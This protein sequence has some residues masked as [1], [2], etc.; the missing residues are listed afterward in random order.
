MNRK[1]K[2]YCYIKHKHF[3]KNQ[4]DIMKIGIKTST[5]DIVDKFTS[6]TDDPDIFR[7]VR[8]SMRS[9]LLMH[10]LFNFLNASLSPVFLFLSPRLDEAWTLVSGDCTWVHNVNCVQSDACYLLSPLEGVVVAWH[11]GHDGTLVR[12]G[13]VDQIW[14]IPSPHYFYSILFNICFKHRWED[15]S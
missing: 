7:L 14:N 4:V 9:K 1:S 10:D 11:I 15:F 13:G 8:I 12:F 3:S 6:S 5:V 2:F